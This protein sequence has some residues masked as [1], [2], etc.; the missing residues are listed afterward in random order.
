MTFLIVSCPST[1]TEK[2]IHLANMVREYFG[3]YREFS[4][5]IRDVL[6]EC[7]RDIFFKY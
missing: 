2:K 3:S 7:S 1:L 6:M 4:V 5:L